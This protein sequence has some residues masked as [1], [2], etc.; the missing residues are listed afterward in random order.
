MQLLFNKG[1]SPRKCYKSIFPAHGATFTPKSSK[2]TISFPPGETLWV[3]SPGVPLV[4]LGGRKGPEG[5][6][7]AGTGAGIVQEQLEWEFPDQPELAD[8]C[9]P[10]WQQG[11]AVALC[12]ERYPLPKT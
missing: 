11:P 8:V 1:E 12:K 3:G 5:R 4:P 2:I 10:L 7:A 9:T 6:E